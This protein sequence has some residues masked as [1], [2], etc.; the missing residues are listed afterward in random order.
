MVQAEATLRMATVPLFKALGL[1]ARNLGRW[2]ICK[3]QPVDI[4]AAVNRHQTR[5]KRARDR[6]DL[7]GGEVVD[8]LGLE[9]RTR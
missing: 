5:R 9:P 7:M 3:P 4:R 8:A 1:P 2:R 6:C